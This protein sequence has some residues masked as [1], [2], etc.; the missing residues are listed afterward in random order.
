MELGVEDREEALLAN[1]QVRPVLI[2]RVLEAQMI[3]EETQEIIQARH[4]GKKKDLRFEKLMVCLCRKAECMC[5][6]MQS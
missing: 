4:Q 5:R 2:D 3:D 6:I 1:F